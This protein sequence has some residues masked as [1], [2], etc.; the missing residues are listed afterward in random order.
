MKIGLT[1]ILLL[2]AHTCND[3]SSPQSSDLIGRW[4]V[5]VTF[6]NQAHYSLRFDAEDAGKGSFL[7]ETERSNWAE[8]AKPSAAK[9]SASSDKRVTFSGPV[10]FPIGNV[11]RQ[12]GTLVFK[13]VFEKEDLISGELAFFPRGQD[14]TDPKA[15][16]S[17]T[18]KFKAARVGS[19]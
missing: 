11:G 18:G 13:G 9:W 15:T 12:T 4:K 8:P 3:L 17:K 10:E 2:A 5:D 1:L 19:D 6:D 7:L 14:P 16:P